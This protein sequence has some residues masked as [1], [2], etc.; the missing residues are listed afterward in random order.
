MNTSSMNII[1]INVKHTFGP[2]AVWCEAAIQTLSF[3]F[4]L[5][6]GS[7]LVEDGYVL[8]YFFKF[9]VKVLQCFNGF[10][11]LELG[12]QLVDF[13]LHAGETFLLLFEL[14]VDA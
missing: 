11:H 5:K 7:C 8:M 2:F 4:C 9:V 14:S 6:C 3:G 10:A 13:L 1:F 12:V